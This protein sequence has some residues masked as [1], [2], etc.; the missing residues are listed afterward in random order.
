MRYSATSHDDAAEIVF[1]LTSSDKFLRAGP[2]RKYPC[3]TDDPWPF[4]AEARW[5]VPITFDWLGGP[6]SAQ[7]ACC[8]FLPNRVATFGRSRRW[9]PPALGPTERS[10]PGSR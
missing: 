6:L 8:T 2:E 1:P 10:K 7:N 3:E 9:R 4:T 5:S